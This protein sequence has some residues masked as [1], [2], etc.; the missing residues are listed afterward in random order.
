[1]GWKRDS[2]GKDTLKITKLTGD[3][4][5]ITREQIAAAAALWFSLKYRA[6]E[7]NNVTP[8]KQGD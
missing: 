7:L 5:E 2:N 1:M 8:Q 4:S 3:E 6:E